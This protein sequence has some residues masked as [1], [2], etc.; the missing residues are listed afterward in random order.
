MLRFLIMGLGLALMATANAEDAALQALL[1]T[2]S[3]PPGVVFELVEND[4]EALQTLLPFIR[5][6]I[7]RLR[8]RHPGIAIA[9]V[10]HGNEQFSLSRQQ[11]G[12]RQALHE[13]VQSLVQE[14]EVEVT[15]CATYASW[16]QVTPEDFPD[17]VQVAESAPARINDFRQL[18]YTVIRLRPPGAQ[19]EVEDF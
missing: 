12:A 17:Y 10:T 14:Q 5:D 4:H 2:H 7:A 8:A 6:N 1:E 13:A 18:G 9:V 11:Q 15:V 3:P 19:P 16:R